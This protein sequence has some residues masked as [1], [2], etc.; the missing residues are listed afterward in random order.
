MDD[1]K[2]PN[3][4][5]YLDE[6]TANDGRQHMAH[7]GSTIT[8]GIEKITTNRKCLNGFCNS[9]LEITISNN[10]L[11]APHHFNVSLNFRNNALFPLDRL[12]CGIFHS[13]FIQK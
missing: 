6:S 1:I 4:H 9:F 12:D 11:L 3:T 8:G 7:I 13:F 5:F 2:T 10:C